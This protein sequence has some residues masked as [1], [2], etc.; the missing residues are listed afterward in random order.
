MLARI[1]GACSKNLDDKKGREAF[2]R[3]FKALEWLGRWAKEMR[4]AQESL[5]GSSGG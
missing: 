4:Q 2:Q 1:G 5:C 3:A